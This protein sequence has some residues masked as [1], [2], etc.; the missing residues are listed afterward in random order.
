MDNKQKRTFIL[1]EVAGSTYAAPSQSVQQMHMIE[2]ITPLPN[3][4]E[5]VDGAVFVRGQVLPAMNL[6]LRF[7]FERT[8]NTLRSRL[9]IV[10]SGNRTVALIADSAREFLSIPPD[11]I[12][13]PPPSIAGLSGSYLEGIATVG[14]RIILIIDIDKIIRTE[15]VASIG[16]RHGEN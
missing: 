3:A 12:Q 2:Q 11:E 16:E 7:G 15:S 5:F 4:P 13:P 1:F 6:R 9:I 14:D 8:A 10:N